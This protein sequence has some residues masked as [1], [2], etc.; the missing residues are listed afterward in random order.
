MIEFIDNTKVM[1]KGRKNLTEKFIEIYNFFLTSLD[2]STIQ[3]KSYNL[4]DYYFEEFIQSEEIKSKPVFMEK[5]GILIFVSYLLGLTDLHYENIILKED[6]IYPIDCET[7]FNI[8][9]FRKEEYHLGDSILSTY[10]LPSSTVKG[11]ILSGLNS[12]GDQTLNNAHYEITIDNKGMS[13]TSSDA[14]VVSK[15][16]NMFEGELFKFSDDINSGFS[17]AYQYFLEHRSELVEKIISLFNGSCSRNLKR[18]TFAYSELL[19][20]SYHPHLMLESNRR[21]FFFERFNTLDNKEKEMLNQN[22][23]PY[24]D[25]RINFDNEYFK[26]FTI[27]DLKNQE[28]L[29]KESL[30]YDKKRYF[31]E[32]NIRERVHITYSSKLRV[33]E[34][35]E[36]LMETNLYTFGSRY[37]LEDIVYQERDEE[38]TELIVTPDTLYFGV[39]GIYL[40]LIE[41]YKKFPNPEE[42]GMLVKDI[43]QL[44]IRLE[45]NINRNRNIQTGLYDG[46]SG[47]MYLLFKAN[48]EYKCID[49]ERYYN[50]LDQI[51]EISRQDTQ[52]DIVSGNSGLL[53]LLTFLYAKTYKKKYIEKYITIVRQQL[54]ATYEIELKENHEEGKVKQYLGYAHGYSGVLAVLAKSQNIVPSSSCYKFIHKLVEVI[55]NEYNPEA[56]WPDTIGSEKYMNNWCHG[57]AGILFG[58]VQVFENIYIEDLESLLKDAVIKVQNEFKKNNSLCHGNYGN[59]L[60]GLYASKV[61]GSRESYEYFKSQL[62][63]TFEVVNKSDFSIENKTFMTGLAGI[64]YWN[65]KANNLN[66][67]LDLF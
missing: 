33:R 30:N 7:I 41:Y 67:S 49:E 62:N 61:L 36:Y 23:I 17:R 45:R 5:F 35:K 9:D 43:H 26:K 37:W 16:K 48:Q 3:I 15:H 27:K 53:K 46:I 63:D 11:A 31:K 28:V 58:L 14:P 4:S 55:S 40:F 25:K 10:L 65:I 18:N 44:L 54:I 64:F 6:G 66:E 34:F 12:L 59:F 60:I 2:Y 50:C 38:E 20:K 57:N 19:W 52:F 32:K 29:L 42:E 51:I 47:I 8:K 1:V 39:T 13:M 24:F 21:E 22:I 56:G